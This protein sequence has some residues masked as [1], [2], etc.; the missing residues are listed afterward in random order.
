[1]RSRRGERAGGEATRAGKATRGGSQRA[2]EE[3]RRRPRYAS[4]ARARG[5]RTRTPDQIFRRASCAEISAFASRRRGG[6]A[7]VSSRTHLEHQHDGYA[8]LV[9][10]AQAQRDEGPVVI[11]LQGAQ[12]SLG[13]ARLVRP[14]QSLRQRPRVVAQSRPH[15]GAR[16][17]IDRPSTPRA[18]PGRRASASGR[19]GRASPRS[20]RCVTLSDAFVRA[21]SLARFLR[22]DF[23]YGA[24]LVSGREI[25]P[26][27][28]PDSQ[29]YPRSIRHPRART[30]GRAPAGVGRFRCRRHRRAT[31]WR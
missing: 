21:S 23:A 24:L 14:R 20:S 16:S 9:V 26:W 30:R 31:R 13:V 7:R 18:A 10:D 15:R 5:A 4:S 28:V 17:R 3:T 11:H 12:R 2:R 25:F 19:E 27:W 8:R 29:N 6:R 1:M 22:G